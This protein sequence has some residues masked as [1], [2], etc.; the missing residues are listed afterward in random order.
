MRV[1]P[2]RPRQCVGLPNGKRN[3][4]PSICIGSRHF[5]ARLPKQPAVLLGDDYFFLALAAGFLAATFFA[6]TFFFAMCIPSLLSVRVFSCF[7]L[8]F[9]MRA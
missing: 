8:T 9:F 6:A 7:A 5:I 4:D 2:D 1:N 3:D